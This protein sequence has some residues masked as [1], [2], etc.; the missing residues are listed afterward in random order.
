[1]YVTDTGLHIGLSTR[2]L[3]NRLEDNGD[4]SPAD[5]KLFYRAVRDFYTRAAEYAIRNLPLCDPV[6]QNSKFV[7]FT[8]KDEQELS[9]VEYFITR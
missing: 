5:V 4:I 8:K 9:Q 6:L 7:D 3:L 1:M 2:Q